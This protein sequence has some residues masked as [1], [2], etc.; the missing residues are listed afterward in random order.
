M[1]YNS[2]QLY[3]PQVLK[4]NKKLSLS[5]RSVG[6]IPGGFVT[7]HV[8]TWVDPL[9]HSVSPP[10][11]LPEHHSAALRRSDSQRRSNMQLLQE[12]D[13]KKVYFSKRPTFFKRSMS[14][15]TRILT[16][17]KKKRKRQE[18]ILSLK[19]TSSISFPKSWTTSP[20]GTI[21]D[22]ASVMGVHFWID[23]RLQ[24][25][26]GFLFHIGHFCLSEVLFALVCVDHVTPFI[27][28]LNGLHFLPTFSINADNSDPTKPACSYNFNQQLKKK[29]Q[30]DRVIKKRININTVHHLYPAKVHNITNRVPKVKNKILFWHHH[31]L[32]FTDENRHY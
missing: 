1:F 16:P 3:F 12:G 32:L 26:T 4:G 30:Q 6:R 21:E 22:V 15:K 9:G 20:E 25:V 14:R 2:T 23:L 19:V 5:V 18:E 29:Q 17:V 8:Y 11:D 7:N 10:P 13:E 27:L 31:S 28:Q 24:K